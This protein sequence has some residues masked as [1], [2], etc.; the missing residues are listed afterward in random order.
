[1]LR[2]SLQFEGLNR[3]L[4]VIMVT[5]AMHGE[6]KS[7]TVA[8]LGVTLALDGNR[9]LLL[10][11]DLRHHRL[12]E[13]FDV[14][15]DPGSRRIVTGEVDIND[16]VVAIDAQRLLSVLPPMAADGRLCRDRRRSACC[17]CSPPARP[18]LNPPELL[19][20]K[21]AAAVFRGA[22]RA[23]RLRPGR[24]APRPAGQ[25]RRGVDGARRRRA[26]PDQRRRV[27]AGT[28]PSCGAPPEAGR[29]SGH[30]RGRQQ[31]PGPPAGQ[32][33]LL[34]ATCTAA[35]ATVETRAPSAGR[36][37]PYRPAE[38]DRLPTTVPGGT[39]EIGDGSRLADRRPGR[40]RP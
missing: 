20:S 16:A 3:P 4:R 6:G 35:A 22:A 23:V 17:P 1:M 27:S 15:N 36:P 13:F 5:S 26:L 10:D 12:H 7:T 19:A 28:D 24:R 40:H 34:R 33:R 38:D 32:L 21:S 2:T 9:V 30:R 29:G 37:A 14:G 25:R 39:S 8:N 11:C 31:H 18:T